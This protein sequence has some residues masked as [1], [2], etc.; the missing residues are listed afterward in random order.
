MKYFITT[1]LFTTIG[2]IATAQKAEWKEMHAFHA[3][4]S[5]TFHPAEEGKLQPVKDNAQELLKAAKDWNTSKTPKGYDAA[6]TAPILKKL[7]EKCASI[8][9]A[10]KAKKD[11]ATLKNLITEAHEVFHEIMEKCK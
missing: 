8:D 6:V 10:V 7:T 1:M 5:K 9:E 2:L 3:I 11:D 4:M